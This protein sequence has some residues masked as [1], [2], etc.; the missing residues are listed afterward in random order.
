MH[1]GVIHLSNI[2]TEIWTSASR[3]HL[4]DENTNLITLIKHLLEKKHPPRVLLK[5]NY[6]GCD[7]LLNSI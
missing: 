5:I 3:K 2:E 7:L 1:L 6:H 4:K